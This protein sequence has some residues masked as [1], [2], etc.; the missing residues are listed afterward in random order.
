MADTQA[1]AEQAAPD[2]AP[3]APTPLPDRPMPT[4][5]IQALARVAEELPGI[6]KD[7]TAA[8]AQGGYSYR[9]IEAITAAAGHLLGRYGVVFV[10]RVV[11][12]RM[13]VVEMNVGGKPWTEE[14]LTIVYTVYGP[15][16]MEDRIEVG[17]LIALGRDNVDKGTNK[18]MT[19]AFK[20]ALLQVLCIGDNK[21]DADSGGAQADA[22]AGSPKGFDFA[23]EGWI[24][25]AEHDAA[26][27]ELAQQLA[28]APSTVKTAFG[29]WYREQGE[30]PDWPGWKHPW[31]ANEF[32][33]VDARL[34]QLL[35]D[36]TQAERTGT[37]TAPHAAQ[38]PPAAPEGTDTPPDPEPPVHG[39]HSAP[40]AQQGSVD[41]SGL[42][43]PDPTMPWDNLPPE[44]Q[45]DPDPE[46]YDPQVVVDYVNSIKAADL[47]AVCATHGQSGAGTA[48]AIR[49]RLAKA[50]VAQ[51]WVPPQ[52]GLA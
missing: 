47:P 28:S 39:P 26:R 43:G 50:L 22:H 34:N 27:A 14:Q 7:A 45:P 15:G 8:P 24:D 42:S 2:R 44:D 32:E 3:E 10:P 19:Q 51:R 41:P 18:C 30:P 21:D 17:P 29:K 36:H 23:D 37:P 12:R 33:R 38:E 46:A 48:K 49:Q 31:T 35:T 13:P 16:G 52:A 5:V 4:N 40:L 11:D 25:Q 20:Y 9:S 6:G 1:P